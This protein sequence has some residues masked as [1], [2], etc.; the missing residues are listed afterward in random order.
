MYGNA[1]VRTTLV[2]VPINAPTPSTAD[3][4][5]REKKTAFT[6][7]V[8]PNPSATDFSLVLSGGSGEVFEIRILDISGR[9][10]QRIKSADNRTVKFGAGLIQ[11][12][13]LV[14]VRQGTERIVLKAI[15]Q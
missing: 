3:G 14:E 15:K 4:N 9:E 2:T 11:G 6:A 7:Q 8:A 5:V 13:Y 10:I 1:T 12:S